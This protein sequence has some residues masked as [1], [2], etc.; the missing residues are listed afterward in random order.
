VY[1]PDQQ[2]LWPGSAENK[3]RSDEHASRHDRRGLLDL[4]RERSRNSGSAFF[5]PAGKSIVSRDPERI[6]P[7]GRFRLELP[8][9]A[10]PWKVH[11]SRDLVHNRFARIAVDQVTRPDGL[12]G[13][14]IV[15]AI[16][17]GICVLALDADGHLLLTREYHYAV[18]RETIEGVSGGIEPGETA[19]DSARRELREELGIEASSL[20]PLTTVDPFTAIMVSPTELFVATGLSR[21]PPRPEGSE[22]IV[23]VRLG[24]GEALQ[25]VW[26][27]QIT[28]APTC[29]GILWLAS[30][31]DSTA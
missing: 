25:M 5:A 15:V 21:I 26:T 1:F 31:Q 17:P 12:P 18:A 11:A 7:V 6:D 13:E 2:V 14:H 24:L 30:R 28:H 3:A 20:E 10:G 16:K 4:R 23:E 9:E 27:G 19:T 22:K 29:I 8:C